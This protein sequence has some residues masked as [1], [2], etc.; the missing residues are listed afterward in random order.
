MRLAIHDHPDHLFAQARRSGHVD[1]AVDADHRPATLLVHLHC[2][3][4]GRNLPE[5]RDDTMGTTRLS[6][7]SVEAYAR[8]TSWPS[9]PTTSMHSRRAPA[10]P[11]CSC[12]WRPSGTGRTTPMPESTGTSVPAACCTSSA[13]RPG[14][15]GTAIWLAPSPQRWQSGSPPSCGPTR[16]RPSIW[17]APAGQW[18]WR[19][20]PRR[21]SPS[22]TR[23][24]SPRRPP[25]PSGPAQASSSSPPRPWPTTSSGP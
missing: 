21:A 10:S 22:A 19:A 5:G 23:R 6:F 11:T 25:R 16:R 7:P 12:S 3:F 18:S 14:P 13:S 9:A 20:A 2:E 1:V 15:P 8:R 4:H 24:P 17:L